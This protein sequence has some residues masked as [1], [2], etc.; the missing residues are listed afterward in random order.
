[1]K[2]I[3]NPFIEKDASRKEY[4]CFGCSPFN[5]TGLK[6]QFWEDE[7]EIIAKWK[8]TKSMEGWL[9]VL[10]GGIQ[11]TLIDELASWTIFLKLK[12]CGVT[13]SMNINYL[14]PVYISKGEI[15]VKG[16]LISTD[17]RIA[18][19]ECSLFDSENNECLNAEVNYF[20]FPEKIA[21]IKY[22]Y[23]GIEAFYE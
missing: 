21:K 9:G 6:L 4:F 14:K 23:P 17:G 7:D 8:P 5:E 22:H 15:T 13:S 10:H 18:K 20:F 11:A 19:I 16:K 2:K 3:K 1:M 12:T